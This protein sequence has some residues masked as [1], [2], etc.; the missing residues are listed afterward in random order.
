MS[1]AGSTNTPWPRTLAAP[2][3]SPGER[4][5]SVLASYS[6]RAASVLAPYA[7]RPAS[8]R[9]ASTA[10]GTPLPP[11]AR[12]RRGELVQ[13]LRV[14]HA[15]ALFQ[16]SLAD[17]QIVQSPGPPCERHPPR[18]HH[19]PERGLDGVLVTARGAIPAARSL[20]VLARAPADRTTQ[21]GVLREPP[22]RGGE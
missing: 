11:L 18:V 8:R 2:I 14:A 16:V 21:V 4:A 17:P 5:T 10:E 7:T 6:E 3:A 9:P 20:D 1:V 13:A 19:Q 15:E 12:D 22:D